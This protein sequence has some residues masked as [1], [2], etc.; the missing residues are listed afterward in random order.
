MSYL[1]VGFFVLERCSVFRLTHPDYMLTQVFINV[2]FFY[3]L[4]CK[5]PK[6]AR[7]IYLFRER[8]LI[9]FSPSLLC[10]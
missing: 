4:V 10:L 3:V 6:T 1:N 5:R 2:G 8:N 7:K 9:R